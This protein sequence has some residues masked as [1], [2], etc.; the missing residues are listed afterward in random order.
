MFGDTYGWSQEFN[1]TAAP[2]VGSNDNIRVIAYGGD[3]T[4][5][6]HVGSCPSLGGG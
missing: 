6:M 3:D 1:F 2:Y 5:S 4:I